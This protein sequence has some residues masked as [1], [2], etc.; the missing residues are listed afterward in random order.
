MAS[1]SRSNRPNVFNTVSY[2]IQTFTTL[3]VLPSTQYSHHHLSSNVSPFTY[4]SIRHPHE[5]RTVSIT[6]TVTPIGPPCTKSDEPNGVEGAAEEDKNRR[7]SLT[8]LDKWA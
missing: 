5:H 1:R 6:L 3:I 2:K 7:Q 8:G 4:V